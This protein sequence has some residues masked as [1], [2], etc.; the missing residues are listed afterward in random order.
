MVLILNPNNKNDKITFSLSLLHQ[1]H[2]DLYLQNNWIYTT[3]YCQPPQGGGGI[4]HAV[5]VEDHFFEGPHP[6]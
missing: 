4:Q 5:P 6:F 3:G 2:A 1:H